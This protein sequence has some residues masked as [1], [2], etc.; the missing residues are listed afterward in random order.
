[1]AFNVND[2]DEFYNFC[3]DNNANEQYLS[4]LHYWLDQF[5]FY[6]SRKMLNNINGGIK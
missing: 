5:D 3:E 6:N 1:M 4:A 2:F